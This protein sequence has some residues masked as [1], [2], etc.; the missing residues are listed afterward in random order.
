M[1]KNLYSELKKLI[2]EKINNNYVSNSKMNI[3]NDNKVLQ[4]ESLNILKKWMD[5]KDSEVKKILEQFDENGVLNDGNQLS[6]TL[7]NDYYKWSMLPVIRCLE[8]SPLFKNN[9]IHVTFSLNIRDETYRKNLSESNIKKNIN[10]KIENPDSLAARVLNNLNNLLLRKFDRDLFEKI[11]K[12]KNLKIDDETITLICGTKENPRSLIDKIVHEKYIPTPQENNLVVVSFYKAFDQKLKENRWYIEAT[13]PWH[14]VTWLE[15]SLMQCVYQTLLTDKLKKEKKSYAKWL[16]EALTRCSMTVKS[17]NDLDT[18]SNLSKKL[19]NKMEGALFTGRRT[20]GYAFLLMQNLFVNDNYPNCIGTSSVDAWNFISELRKSSNGSSNKRKVLIPVGTHAHELSMV[21]STLFPEIDKG[22]PLTQV[23]NHYLYYRFATLDAIPMLPDTLSTP[24][25]MKIASMIEIKNKNDSSSIPFLSIIS[26]ARQDSGDVNTF[27]DY[28]RPYNLSPNNNLKSTFF[29]NIMA[30]E[31]DDIDTLKKVYGIPNY[32]KFGAGGLFGDGVNAWNKS[33]K[34]ISMAVKATRV[35]IGYKL[36]EEYP[37][38][39]GNSKN[40]KI[41]KLNLNGTMNQETYNRVLNRAQSIKS[42]N[43]I[44][45]VLKTN[46]TGNITS[47]QINNEPSTKNIAQADFYNVLA[48]IFS[49]GGGK[50]K[51]ITTY[52]KPELVKLAIKHKVSLKTRE[53]TIKTKKQLFDSL[54]RKKVI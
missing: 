4:I 21:I 54:K 42:L 34:N 14:K 5:N 51:E 27:V 19:G 1:A 16:L 31:I 17:I 25:F 35:F 22:Y 45:K 23:L 2:P 40:S 24:A 33:V 28:L 52:K 11:I 41:N 36:S 46:S 3:S 15:T 13:G 38:K 48:A 18:S 47:E 30:S 29:N 49:Q 8:K 20:G 7:F 50:K 9:P 26:S 43:G 32:N 37:V 44:I 12:T 10:G 6:A 39:T 53:K